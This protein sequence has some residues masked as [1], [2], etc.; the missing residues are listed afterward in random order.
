M[1]SQNGG[2]IFYVSICGFCLFITERVW[3]TTTV[4]GQK[5]VSVLKCLLVKGWKLFCV[6]FRLILS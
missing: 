6:S 1:G 3:P 5:Y 2:K 4:W